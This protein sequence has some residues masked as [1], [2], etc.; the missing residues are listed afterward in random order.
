[1]IAAITAWIRG[2]AEHPYVRPWGLATPILVLIVC[3]PLLRPILRPTEISQNELGRLAT[4]QAIVEYKTL[5]IDHTSFKPLQEQI[6]EPDRTGTGTTRHFSTQPPVLAAILAGP[7]WVMRRIGIT[8]ETNLA[9]ATYL[10]TFF[11]S[12][13]PVAA[14]AGLLYRMGRLFELTRP[15]RMAVAMAGVFG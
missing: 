14:A 8:F 5:A 11:G 2:R 13:L 1:M 10:L 15:W 9:L 7:Y 4:I 12:T 6:A 3:L